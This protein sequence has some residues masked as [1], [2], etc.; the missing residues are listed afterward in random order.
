MYLITRMTWI[1]SFSKPLNYIYFLKF[2][3]MNKTDTKDFL[4]MYR[5]MK[6]SRYFEERMEKVY[7]EG[8]QPI[9][10]IGSGPVPGEM[11]LSNGQEPAAAGMIVHLTKD[12]TVTATHRPHHQA[13][14]NR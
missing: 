13:I 12:D 14:T 5:A 9:F 3:I 11:H 8:K 4:W 6:T 10:N 1:I 2:H 7:L